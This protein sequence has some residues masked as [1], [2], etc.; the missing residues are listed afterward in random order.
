MLNNNNKLI[1]QSQFTEKGFTKAEN[2]EQNVVSLL[3]LFTLK[4][5]DIYDKTNSFLLQFDNI[6]FERSMI[7]EQH[8]CNIEKILGEFILFCKKREYDQTGEP[9][10]MHCLCFT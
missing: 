1:L 9:Y 8:M 7:A 4:N 6:N 2:S 10:R 3:F 5:R